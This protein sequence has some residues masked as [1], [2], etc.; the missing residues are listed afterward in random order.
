VI[1]EDGEA[2]ARGVLRELR[3]RRFTP[4]AWIGFLDASFRRS[5][6]RRR[7]RPRAFRE[8]LALGVAGFAV[9]GAVAVVDVRLAWVGAAWWAAIVLML[10]WHLGMLERPNGT[11]IAGIG[12]ANILCFVRAG[13]VPALPALSPAALAIALG[14]A[15]ITDVLDGILARRRDEVTRL[16]QWLDGAV[17]GLML[18]AAAASLAS[19]EALPAWTAALV[20]VRYGA[21]WLLVAG[22]YFFAAMQPPRSGYVPGRVPGFVLLL[23]LMLAALSV[24]GAAAVVAAGAAGG[25][26]TLA[27][28]VRRLFPA[29]PARAPRA[30]A[31]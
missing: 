19:A 7:Q 12:T 25:L 20:V 16:G 26:V 11:A 23:G 6:V 4:I 5:N 10:D 28:T 8:T 27:A 22:I 15:H 3:E 31:R 24:P 14:A 13:L 21:P 18:G 17:D 29:L 9:W 1:E 2:W 30:P